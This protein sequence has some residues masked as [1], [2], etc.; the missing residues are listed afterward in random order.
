MFSQDFKKVRLHK[1]EIE[2][3]NTKIE[4]LPKKT[5]KNLKNEI[6]E[7]FNETMFNLRE[8]TG[9][10]NYKPVELWTIGEIADFVKR[11]NKQIKEA[12]NERQTN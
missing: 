3:I 10:G 6:I 2:R 8:A 1:A 9:Q 4:K 12:K 7:N 11:K 5:D